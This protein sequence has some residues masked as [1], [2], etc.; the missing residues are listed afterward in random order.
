MRDRDRGAAEIEAVHQNAGDGAVEDADPIRPAGPRDRDDAAI[1]TT[2]SA[3]R[4]AR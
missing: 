1:K 2:T 3:I 4:I